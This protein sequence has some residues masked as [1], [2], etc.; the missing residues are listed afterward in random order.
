L[1]AVTTRLNVR[2]TPRASKNAVEG[3]RDG[4]LIIRV[5]A[6]PVDSAAND[7]VVELLAK[8]LGVAKRQ[9]TIARGSTGR[10]K[11][12]EVEGV[13]HDQLISLLTH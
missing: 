11:V 6:P 13:S 5:T 12:V 7:A 3:F 10:N 4:A 2:V 8:T 1:G 9:I